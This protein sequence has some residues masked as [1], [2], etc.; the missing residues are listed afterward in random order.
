MEEEVE[1]KE[2]E[3]K[4]EITMEKIR[5]DYLALLAEFAALGILMKA[6]LEK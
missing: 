6:E 3:V 2:E 4:E 5:K 1:V